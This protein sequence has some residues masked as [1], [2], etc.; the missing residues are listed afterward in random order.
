MTSTPISNVPI[1]L[2]PDTEIDLNLNR[3]RKE[4][5]EDEI[6]LQGK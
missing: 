6:Y 5:E 1:G 3:M 2:F 4:W